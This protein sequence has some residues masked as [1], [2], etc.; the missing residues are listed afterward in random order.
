M[1]DL[2]STVA[3]Y[4]PVLQVLNFAFPCSGVIFYDHVHY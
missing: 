1:Q 2:R 3:G 4:K